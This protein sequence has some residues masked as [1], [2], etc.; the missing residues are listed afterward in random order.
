MNSAATE[1]QEQ[2]HELSPLNRFSTL[3]HH[4]DAAKKTQEEREL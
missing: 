3:R 2:L 1:L 4:G